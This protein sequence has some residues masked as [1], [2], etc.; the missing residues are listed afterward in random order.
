MGTINYNEDDRSILRTLLEELFNNGESGMYR[1]IAKIDW[2]LPLDSK[3]KIKR[4]Q[5][6]VK[7]DGETD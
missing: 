5:I 2:A 7:I 4:Y 3:V 6:Y 1:E